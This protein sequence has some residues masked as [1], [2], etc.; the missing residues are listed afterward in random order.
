MSGCIP[1]AEGVSHVIYR[2]IVHP[3]RLFG[4]VPKALVVAY[5]CRLVTPKLRTEFRAGAALRTYWILRLIGKQRLTFG[6]RCFHSAP[7]TLIIEWRCR[8]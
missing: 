1:D 4:K 8:M 6:A 2:S 7:H 3:Y 5:H